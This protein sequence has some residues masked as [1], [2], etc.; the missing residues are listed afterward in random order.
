[1]RLLPLALIAFPSLAT[2]QDDPPP[3]PV[4][5]RTCDICKDKGSDD[6]A[7]KPDG[8]FDEGEMQELLDMA[9][10]GLGIDIDWTS[11]PEGED[12]ATGT[13]NLKCEN[14]DEPRQVKLHVEAPY[15]GK[16]D[17]GRS[18]ETTCETDA[19]GNEDCTIQFFI[20]SLRSQAGN[21]APDDAYLDDHPYWMGGLAAMAIHELMHICFGDDESAEEGTDK[22]SCSHLSISNGMVKLLC[23]FIR[24]IQACLKDLTECPVPDD[25]S[26]EWLAQFEAAEVCL[27]ALRKAA[28]D[29]VAGE[30]AAWN[31]EEGI[32]NANKCAGSPFLGT[33]NGCCTLPPLDPPPEGGWTSE[34]PPLKSDCE[35]EC[36]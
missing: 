15:R 10:A 12:A 22:T 24:E 5:C 11:P 21:N 33:G 4:D 28:C 17:N 31:S 36:E 29:M 8:E 7:P 13:V 1:M 18:G 34:D 9:A 23:D 30:L 14:G 27:L 2:A 20:G 25:P 6:G 35:T 26:D 3:L 19:Q 16:G 32:K